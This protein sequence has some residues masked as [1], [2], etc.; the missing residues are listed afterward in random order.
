MWQNDVQ[1][2]SYSICIQ[3]ISHFYFMLQ[4]INNF[5]CLSTPFHVPTLSG[6]KH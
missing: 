4:R 6:E 1:I 3:E 2:A 5:V